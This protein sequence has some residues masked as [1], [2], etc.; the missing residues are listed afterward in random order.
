MTV[1][2]NYFVGW[3]EKKL[4]AYYSLT[5]SSLHIEK[6]GIK[7]E[8]KSSNKTLNETSSFKFKYDFIIFTLVQV[9]REIFKKF[10]L[11]DRILLY[12]LHQIRR[13]EFSK[14]SL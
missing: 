6:E 3:G 11:N 9:F 10:Y 12:H 4:M 13:V 7:I 2:V 14:W 5:Y 8:D 1:Q